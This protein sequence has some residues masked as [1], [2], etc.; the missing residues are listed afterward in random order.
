MAPL[1]I[2][3]RDQ[4]KLVFI[5]ALTVFLVFASG[6]FIGHQRAS[7]FYQAGSVVQ[8]LPLPEQLATS[9]SVIDA[10]LPEKIEAGED[11]DVDQPE[12][13]IANTDTDTSI[14]PEVIKK[15]ADLQKSDNIDATQIK[16]EQQR[17]VAQENESLMS[18]RA[19]HNDGVYKRSDKQHSGS[20]EGLRVTA[21]YTQDELSKIKYSIQVGVYGRLLN[22]EN[23]METLQAQKYQAYITNY[24]NK[25]NAIRYNVRYGYF[26]DKKSAISSLE[27]FKADQR[28]DG[29]LV[30]FSAANIVD[31]A[32][33]AK[34]NQP[35]HMPDHSE[36]PG[37]E[38]TPAV[39]SEMTQDKVSQADVLN[40]VLI[41][42]N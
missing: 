37:K 28:G 13:I 32:D 38:I 4:L 36:Q 15:A 16:T 6:F 34:I 9:E 19:E 29:Y 18:S 2:D 21:V 24:T 27:K 12:A 40:E 10:H 22:A 3:S 14:E 31:V 11:I 42:A 17:T 35:V 39:P 33:A 1:L 25:K 7:V 26:S 5:S 8:S 41:K 20:Q 30:R 23:M